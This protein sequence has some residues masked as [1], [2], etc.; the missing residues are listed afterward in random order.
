VIPF[1]ILDWTG[2]AARYVVRQWKIEFTKQAVAPI[3]D[4]RSAR[5]RAESAI[6]YEEA[7]AH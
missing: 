3:F 6:A 1:W 5:M 7:S 4:V 2:K